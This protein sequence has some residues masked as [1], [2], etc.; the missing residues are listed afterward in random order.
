MDEITHYRQN[1]HIGFITHAATILN[2]IYYYSMD[3]I[4]APYIWDRL[5]LK[6]E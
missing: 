3:Y 5:G 2:G 1:R 4:N 6:D